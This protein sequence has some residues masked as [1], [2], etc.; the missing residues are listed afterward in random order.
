[1]DGFATAAAAAVRK[2]GWNR[3]RRAEAGLR[4]AIDG[5]GRTVRSVRKGRADIREAILCLVPELT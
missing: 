4:E 2:T 1:M 3:G 5:P